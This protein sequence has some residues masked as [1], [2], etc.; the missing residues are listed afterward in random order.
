MIWAKYR[1]W[2]LLLVYVGFFTHTAIW[3]YWGY[4]NVGHLGFGEFFGTLRSGVVT[5]GTIFTLAVFIHAL[6]FGG[7]FC[8]WLCHWGITQDFAAWIMKKCGIRPKMQ[9]L[10]SRLIPW[11]WFLVIIAQV[12]FYWVYT[13]FPTEISLNLAATPVWTGVPRSIL[14]IS[15]TTL[16]SG[17]ILIF[18][19]GERAFCRSICTFRLWFSWFEK[20]AP[21]K[22][23]Q[24]KECTSC[25]RECSQVCPMGINVAEE[26]KTLG[27]IKNNDCIK[28]HICI[29]ACP[30]TALITSM[31][32]N[33]FHKEG[34]PVKAPGTFSSSISVLQTAM[35]VII[36]VLLGFDLGGNVSLSLGFLSGFL[37]I[38]IIVSRTLSVF[39]LSTTLLII[40]GLW[41]RHDM[42]DITSL[43]KGLTVIAIFILIAKAA[44]FSGGFNFFDDK[45]HN[46]KVPVPLMALV[47]LTASGLAL[48]ETNNSRLLHMAN[49]ALKHDD[50]KAYASI[51][52]LCAGSHSDPA[53]ACYDLG[54][55]Q[56]MLKEPQKAINSFK[57]SLEYSFSIDMAEN[58]LRT[59]DAAEFDEHWNQFLD[60][61]IQTHSDIARF[62]LFKG[63]SLQQDKDFAAAEKMFQELLNTQPDFYET[64]IAFGALRIEQGLIAEATDFVARAYAIAPASSAYFMA[65]INRRQ[66]KF[67]EAEKYYA[68][69]VESDPNNA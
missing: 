38:H 5:A 28:C 16:V 22:V 21:H 57:R 65:D 47:L 20:I 50:N 45:S 23:R 29:G 33:E 62:K 14:L 49:A 24:T 66:N 43:A 13:G 39:E 8:G 68:E 1:H 2:L 15:M 3:H 60:F 55:T 7:L 36:L 26:I 53:R 48:Y 54:R 56:L 51:M 35:A 58:M 67:Q 9:H 41:F 46:T 59:F 31:K 40:A 19:F 18:L 37:I 44:N 10:D 61:L 63:K 30:N 32:K 64:Y 17:F 11:V 69:A 6:F 42:N 25:Q 34:Q 27:H 12:V 4:E 52:E